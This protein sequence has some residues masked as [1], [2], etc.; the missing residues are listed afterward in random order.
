MIPFL[1]QVADHFYQMGDISGRC[2]VFPNRRSMVFF[3]KYLCDA[4]AA[5]PDSK[6]MVAPQMITIND[7]FFSV[8][9]VQAADRVR[10]LLELYECYRNINPKAEPLDEFVF[11]G[12]VIWGISMTWT[13]ILS[14]RG[15]FSPMFPIT[16]SCRTLSVI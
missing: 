2:F 7:L 8:A 16:V 1:K 5:A 10:L 13:S 9:G 12:D 11:W 3:R 14:I 6:P 15:S 4:V